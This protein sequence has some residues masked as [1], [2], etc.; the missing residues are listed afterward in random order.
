MEINA[1]MQLKQIKLKVQQ[2]KQ[3]HTAEFESQTNK[4]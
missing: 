2:L 4:P 3:R 1:Q